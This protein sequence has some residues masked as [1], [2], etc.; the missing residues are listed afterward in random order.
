ME[1]A[2]HI[3]NLVGTRTTVKHIAQD[4]QLVDSKLLNKVANG[5]NEIIGATSAN[6][7]LDYHVDIGLLIAIGSIL[8]KQFLN[9]IGET[10][11]QC[12]V[13]L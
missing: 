13:N 3:H 2:K 6:D 4:V 10:A 7:S 12:L 11:R 9:D 8:M 5:D 1:G